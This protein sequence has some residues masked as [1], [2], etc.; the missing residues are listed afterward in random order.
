VTGSESKRSIGF[1]CPT[2]IRT[3][4]AHSFHFRTKI[5]QPNNMCDST[6]TN[7][8]ATSSTDLSLSDALVQLKRMVLDNKDS[9]A[10][11]TSVEVEEEC[12]R[13]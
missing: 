1:L 4:P 7:M 9:S 2:H 6:G 10:E 11:D 13:M 5:R 3:S 12:L 8:R